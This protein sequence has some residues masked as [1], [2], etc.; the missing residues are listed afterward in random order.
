MENSHLLNVMQDYN[1]RIDA[2][3]KLLKSVK[4]FDLAIELALETHAIT[5]TSAVSNSDTPTFCDDLLNGWPDEA[6]GTAPTGP[7]SGKPIAYHLWHI[8]RIEDLVANLL[9]AK[10]PQVFDD[11]WMAKLNVTV[12]DTGNAMTH[13]AVADFSRQVDKQ[14]LINYRNAVGGR[15]RAVLK[16]LSPGD[17]KQKPSAAYLAQLVNEGG[18]TADKNSIWLKDFWGRHTVAGL[19]ILPLTR[20]HMMHL[21][22]C[23]AARHFEGGSMT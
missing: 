11:Q 6:N 2:L 21:P 9:I 1:G 7:D 8:A 17:L 19:I 10:Q 18:L 3:R 16:S 22:D 20:H 14:A 23:F 13:E 4:S 15:T 12:K 5:H